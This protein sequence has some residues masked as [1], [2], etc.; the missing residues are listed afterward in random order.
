MSS[1]GSQLFLIHLISK[2]S[3]MFH[4]YNRSSLII[5][6]MQRLRVTRRFVSFQSLVCLDFCV[7]LRPFQRRYIRRDCMSRKTIFVCSTVC[8]VLSNFVLACG[9]LRRRRIWW[10]S[11]CCWLKGKKIISGKSISARIILRTS[12]LNFFAHWSPSLWCKTSSR[13]LV[14][15]QRIKLLL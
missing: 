6:I 4:K 13:W 7:I 15:N 10:W 14:L 2:Y 12:F 9:H 3:K 5:K 11:H 1:N 8:F